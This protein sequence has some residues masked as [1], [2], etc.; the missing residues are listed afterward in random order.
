MIGGRRAGGPVSEK[1]EGVIMKGLK[2][3]RNQKHSVLAKQ[4]SANHN[5]FEG[6]V[7]TCLGRNWRGQEEYIYLIPILSIKN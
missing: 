7:F 5:F 3:Y 2:K 6:G 1:G 4:F